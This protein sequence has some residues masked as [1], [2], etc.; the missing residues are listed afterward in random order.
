MDLIT[1][2]PKNFKKPKF[3]VTQ[4]VAK[5]MSPLWLTKMSRENNYQL[6]SKSK[7]QYPSWKIVSSKFINVEYNFESREIKICFVHEN[8]GSLKLSVE[9]WSNLKGKLELVVVFAELLSRNK[10]D[11][12][13]MLGETEEI[14]IKGDVWNKGR[15][16]FDPEFALEIRWQTPGMCLVELKQGYTLYD[17]M[18]D[19]EFDWAPYGKP[20]QIYSLMGFMHIAKIL[21]PYVDAGIKMWQ[22]MD[23]AADGLWDNCVPSYE[24]EKKEEEDEYTS[25]PV[26]PNAT[27]YWSHTGNP[28]DIKATWA[29]KRK[30]D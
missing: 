13:K 11:A 19:M 9:Q 26:Q 2:N 17:Q 28:V 20:G 23:N 7:I 30:T 22:T 25:K 29:D 12:K 24:E 16:V 27:P 1:G 15:I 3:T 4:N 14:L 6:K 10:D 18:K 5:L 21:A 8:A